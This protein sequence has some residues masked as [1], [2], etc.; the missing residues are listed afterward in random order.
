M[1]AVVIAINIYFVKDTVETQ[2]P[3]NW[4]VYLGITIYAIFYLG[5]C[6][7]LVIHMAIAMGADFLTNYRVSDLLIKFLLVFI[8]KFI[9]IYHN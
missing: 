9:L 1:S 2:L 3:D 4:A 8:N 7:Y 5:F 6:F